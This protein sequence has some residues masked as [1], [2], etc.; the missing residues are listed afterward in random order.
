MSNNDGLSIWMRIV[1]HL[2]RGQEEDDGFSAAYI[3]C[4]DG[5]AEALG[6][7]RAHVAVEVKK[8]LQEG[9]IEERLRHVG[10]QFKRKVYFLTA[11]GKN[12]ALQTLKYYPDARGVIQVRDGAI[13]HSNSERIVRMEFQISQMQ[14]ILNKMAGD[15]SVRM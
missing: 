6:V 3:R 8:L 7:S 2:E 4:Q 10:G 5:L 14:A 12:T 9:L 13:S 1:A 11:E 15:N